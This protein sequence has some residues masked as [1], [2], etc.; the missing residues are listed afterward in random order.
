MAAT[1]G[2][3]LEWSSY[4]EQPHWVVP[5]T[6]TPMPVL[7]GIPLPP[8]PASVGIHGH[9]LVEKLLQKFGL[10]TERQLRHLEQRLAEWSSALE[11]QSRQY[12]EVSKQLE[13]RTSTLWDVNQTWAWNDNVT[14]R[15]RKSGDQ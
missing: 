8:L 13:A 2:L 7:Q 6:D 3:E 15:F 4:A 10:V 5:F 12:V 9:G 11:H 1:L 14:L